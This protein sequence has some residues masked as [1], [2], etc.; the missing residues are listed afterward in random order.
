[1]GVHKYTIFSLNYYTTQ[2]RIA[3]D[4]YVYQFLNLY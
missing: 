1:M 3:K 2:K 4:Q